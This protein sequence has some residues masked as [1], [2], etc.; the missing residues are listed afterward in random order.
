MLNK[1]TSLAKYTI[2]ILYYVNKPLLMTFLNFTSGH[3]NNACVL[4]G[5]EME[6]DKEIFRQIC[7][8]F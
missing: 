2:K 3:S 4:L 5:M 6:K 7:V 8:Y 1:Q